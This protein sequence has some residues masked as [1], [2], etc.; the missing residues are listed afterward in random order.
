TLPLLAF[1]FLSP[2]VPKI[3][4]RLGMEWT[5]F[6]ALCFL[7][8]GIIIRSLF[9][10]GSL[11]TGTVLIGL[12]IAI[13]NVLLPAFIKMNFPLKMGIMTG[14]YVVSMNIFGA[15]GSGLSVPFASF[16]GMGW[17]GSLGIWAILSFLA[18]LIWIPQLKTSWEKQ[19]QTARASADDAPSGANVWRSPLAWF[20]TMFMG[21]QSLIFYT[22]ITW[23]PDLLQSYG[24]TSNAAGWLLFLLQF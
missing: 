22:L 5:I 18:F 3:S 8:I 23:I 16:Q 19:E 20:I 6:I 21:L 17:Q 15:L 12:A 2:F 10:V 4:D 11:F 14:I 7:T 13:G 9:G 24:Y 1:A